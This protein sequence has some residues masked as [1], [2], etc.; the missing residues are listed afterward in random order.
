[1]A[2]FSCKTEIISGTGAIWEL[3]RMGIRRMLLVAAPFFAKTDMPE[4]IK[5]AANADQM[6]IFSDIQPDPTVELAA[7]GTA[8]LQ[9]FCPDTV[10][11]LGGGSAMDC[12]KAMVY[13]SG[14]KIPLIAIPTTSGSGSEVTNFSVLT[15]DGVKHPLV[16]DALLPKAAILDANLLGSLP[17]SLIAD[18]GFDVV[19]HAVESYVASLAGA[20]SRAMAAEALAVV[21]TLLP[22]SYK[23]ETAVRLDIHQA[24]TMAGIAFSQSGLGL[25]H[26][27][28]HALG[29]QFHIP[30]GRLNAILL[31]TVIE[32]NAAANGRYAEL[33]RKAGLGGASEVQAVRNLKNAL[34]HLR[35]DLDLPTTLSQAGVSP[36]QITE[37]LP[38]L[39]ASTLSDPCIGTNPVRIDGKMVEKVLRQVMGNG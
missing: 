7:K 19:A 5:K 12:A 20:M 18:G 11:A 17:K 6:E 31:P 37:K 16:D 38:S 39:V 32:T 9:A 33:S 25:C 27:L 4:K 36:R 1:M 22:R 8:I 15:H 2:T 24:A 3:S 28:A 14:K 29:G 10:V 26:A 13:F 30:H 21:G 23:G 35:K 34:H